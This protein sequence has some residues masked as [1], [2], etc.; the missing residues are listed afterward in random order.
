MDM[1]LLACIEVIFLA[2][3]F[4]KKKISNLFSDILIFHDNEFCPFLTKNIYL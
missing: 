1:S 2:A 3:H 4:D